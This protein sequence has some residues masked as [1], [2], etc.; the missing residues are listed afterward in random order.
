MGQPNGSPEHRRTGHG[1]PGEN[2][3]ELYGAEYYASRCGP[4]VYERNEHWLTF[5]GGVADALVRSFMPR[6]VFDAGCALGFL[7]ES[8]WDRGVET[9]GRD[10]SEFAVSRIRMDV[11]P[12][13]QVGSIADPIEGEY[14]LVTCIEVLEHMTETEA[15]RAIAAMT[16]VTSRILFSSS[17]TDLSEPTHI[18]VKPTAYWLGQFAREGFAPLVTHDASYL[19]PHAYVLERSPEAPSPRDLAVFSSLVR[20]R[21]ALGQLGNRA[22]E[23]C[24]E[25]S[26]S[27]GFNRAATVAQK[28]LEARLS[29]AER[30]KADR[31]RR[32]D[33]ANRLRAASAHRAAEARRG[34]IEMRALAMEEKRRREEAEAELH[35]IRSSAFWRVTGPLQRAAR[36]V[37]APLRRRVRTILLFLAERRPPPPPRP[38][39]L[40]STLPGQTP[41]EAGPAV[42]EETVLS[43]V[44]EP[45]PTEPE[46]DVDAVIMRHFPELDPLPTLSMVGGGR[47]VNIVTDSINAGSLYGGVGTALV[48][49]AL[50][51]ERLDATLRLI[52]RTEPPDADNIR[53]VLSVQGI[54]LPGNVELLHSPPSPGGREIPTT[55]RDL[56]LTTSW[57]T[58]W[59][60]RKS[61]G[62]ERIVYLLQ[63]DE[64][65]FYPLGDRHLR[66]AETLA[67]PDIAFVVNSRLLLKHLVSTGLT[68]LERNGM[69]F[70]PAF[71]DSHYYPEQEENPVRRRFFLYARPNH[72]RNLYLRSLEAL[73]AAIVEGVLP[74]DG[75][76]FNFVGKDADRLTLPG[77]VKPRFRS[78]LGWAEYAALVRRIDLG[79]SLMY[80]P[81]PSYPPL[82]LAASGAVVV[83]NR[84]PGKVSLDR[85]SGNILC[86]EPTVSG[87][88]EALRQGAALAEDRETRLANWRGNLLLRD[89]R[90]SFSS[91]LDRVAGMV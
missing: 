8:L 35:R 78:D 62:P 1:R 75:W 80:T 33:E 65:M 16:R 55:S 37:P 57:W 68:N 63:E 52:T 42:L 59:C 32:T 10:I 45:P 51:A 77:G 58:T 40:P 17:P 48:L 24:G 50:M 28:G 73:S 71:P 22:Q 4:V 72:P 82:D 76:E 30:E 11:R 83:T 12:F 43:P 13:C 7:V 84:F 25:L 9:H 87:L 20:L 85:Y 86:A 14:D 79:L 15:V 47:R 53:T 81:H 21:V 26:E 41:P 31:V 64:R 67:S 60:T 49:G 91:V 74:E 5:F 54:P 69:S 23:L 34:E 19:C 38:E 56:F 44:P 39:P 18:N 46:T 29:Q 61:V 3:K 66:C 70:E 89:W 27:R 90:I 2:G 88:L 6:R 36:R